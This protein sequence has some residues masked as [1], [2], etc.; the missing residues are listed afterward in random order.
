MIFALFCRR[1][2]KVS[3][4]WPP[5]KI[6]IFR[7]ELTVFSQKGMQLVKTV[8]FCRKMQIFVGGQN[9]LTLVI[10]LQKSAKVT[11]IRHAEDILG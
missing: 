1:V 11:K 5:T 2:T 3:S 4:V 6:C 8:S 7:Q 10:L 9:E